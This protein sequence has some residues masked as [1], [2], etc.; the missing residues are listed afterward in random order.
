M[1]SSKSGVASSARRLL[2]I[3]LVCG[4]IVAIAFGFTQGL[5]P[6]VSSLFG[7]GISIVSMLLLS[8][9]V[10]RAEQSALV[11]PK[12]SMGLLYFGAVQRFV[13]IVVFFIIGIKALALDP[14]G[15]SVGFIAA[16]VSNIVGMHS[17][18]KS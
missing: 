11:D 15:I 16:Q 6:A 1:N 2:I 3:Q 10:R 12:K 9:G 8:S 14:L 7:V 4:A 17:S 13:L 5:D 18:N